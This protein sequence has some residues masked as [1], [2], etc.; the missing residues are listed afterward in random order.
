MTN[1]AFLNSAIRPI[2]EP[3][4]GW[5]GDTPSINRK[6]GEPIYQRFDINDVEVRM[7]FH[8]GKLTF[9]V[10]GWGANFNRV[11]IIDQNNDDGTLEEFILSATSH[12]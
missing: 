12:E 4:S 2:I 10:R 8:G 1:K 11:H 5:Y 6:P 7:Q 3:V 9:V